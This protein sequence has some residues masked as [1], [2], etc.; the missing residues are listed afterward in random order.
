MTSPYVRRQ[1]LAAELRRLR[2]ARDMTT[3][4]VAAAI[5][6]SRMVIGRLENAQARPNTAD[7]MKILN[8][9]RVEGEEWKHLVI[10][11]AEA[12]ER[13]W[14]HSDADAMGARQSLYADL[15]YGAVTIQELAHTFVPGLLQTR[16]YAQARHTANSALGP[17]SYVSDRAVDARQNRQRML[18]RPN[19]PTYEVVLDELAVRRWTVPPAVLRT[20]LE[21]LVSVVA[22]TPK[23]SVRVLPIAARIADYAAAGT[24]F[25]RYT[26]SD[27][28]PVVVAVD[29]AASDLILT[30]LAEPDQVARYTQLYDRLAAAAL[31]PEDSITLLTEAAAALPTHDQG[32]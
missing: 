1:R 10:I 30:D 17:V 21:H 31:A 7:V 29:T 6:K 16:E 13:G 25:S 26:F 22:Q 15:E 5:G 27:G 14:W 9:L 11:S 8:T 2:E 3:A 28:D 18:D 12:A 19:G 24:S 23:I 4:D 20:Q 32:S